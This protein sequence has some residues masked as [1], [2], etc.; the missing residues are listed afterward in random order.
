M[1]K[2][3]REEETNNL[4]WPNS[5]GTKPEVVQK[6]RW[7]TCWKNETETGSLMCREV[8]LNCADSAKEEVLHSQHWLQILP[9]CGP[10]G[11]IQKGSDN[12]YGHTSKRKINCKMSLCSSGEL[13]GRDRLGE[14]HLLI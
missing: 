9:A 11:P 12:P 4:S 8:P 10:E 13:H 1:I 2:K 3:A 14:I 6:Y 7:G 5:K